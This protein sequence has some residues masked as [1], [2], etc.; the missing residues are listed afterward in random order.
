MPGL[1]GE[2][3]HLQGA[4]SWVPGGINGLSGTLA[5]AAQRGS[6]DSSGERRI[7][8]QES[9]SPAASWDGRKRH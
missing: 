1:L 5:P 2:Y 6:E 8:V 9:L 4:V 7:I 3:A